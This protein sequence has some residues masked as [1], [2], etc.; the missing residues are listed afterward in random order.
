MRGA[1]R[2]ET[3]PPRDVVVAYAAGDRGAFEQLFELARLDIFRVVRRYFRSAFDQEEAFQEAWLQIYRMHR[4]FDVNR[5]REFLPWARQVARNRCLDLLKAR[6]RRPELVPAEVD[7]RPGADPPQLEQLA[8]ARVREAVRAFA[9]R[10][11]D[12]ERRFF[13]LCFV[14]ELPHDQ[15][16]RR[17]SISVRRSKY[18]NKKLLARMLDN[19]SLRRASDGG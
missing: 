13:E 17:L 6:G 10:L 18:L 16:A 11:D 2:G 19:A 7:R 9:R 8:G 5:H 14:A 12:Q 4:R 15:I 1:S 3:D